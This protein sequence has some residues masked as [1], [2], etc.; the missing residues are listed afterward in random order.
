MRPVGGEQEAR[1]AGARTARIGTVSTADRR[2]QERHRAPASSVPIPGVGRCGHA[3][4][5]GLGSKSHLLFAHLL[6][7]SSFSVQGPVLHQDGGSRHL[8]AAAPSSSSSAAL[9]VIVSCVLAI[10]NFAITA[11]VIFLVFIVIYIG[12]LLQVLS[13]FSCV[14]E[15]ASMNSRYRTCP[16]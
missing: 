11:G 2:H 1:C 9:T 16:V 8:L 5:L 3:R 15:N 7:F 6:R 13:S 10:G 12:A 14:T 4:V